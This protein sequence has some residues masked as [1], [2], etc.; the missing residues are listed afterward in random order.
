MVRAQKINTTSKEQ[1]NAK[2]K[3]YFRNLNA[4][5]ESILKGS[6]KE[7]NAI[8]M[9]ACYLLG[10]IG[11]GLKATEVAIHLS[12]FANIIIT[13]KILDETQ[14]N[15]QKPEFNGI[16]RGEA[17]ADLAAL[18]VL[19]HIHSN[20]LIEECVPTVEE[21][22]ALGE[23]MRQLDPTGN[24]RVGDGEI[25]IYKHVMAVRELFKNVLI[26]SSDAD[27][28]HLFKGVHSVAVLA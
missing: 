25:S 28:T 11:A 1:D 4:K 16:K 12:Q 18:Y 19:P 27:V 9:D 23:K 5:V 20:I 6:K 22:E 3:S 7:E 21:K 14:R 13:R 8:Y 2:K 26:L 10:A 24:S 17:L 15:L